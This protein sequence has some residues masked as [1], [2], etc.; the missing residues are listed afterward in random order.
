[1]SGEFAGLRAIV[2]GGASGI[3]AAAATQLLER[4]AA[5]AVLDLD[6]ASS[7]DGAEGIVADVRDRDSV[8]SAVARAAELLG[9][10]DIV[11]N[12][13]GVGAVGTVADNADDEWMRVLDIN[14]VGMARVAA[15]ALPWLQRS[16]AAVI[17]N[18][19]SI[20]A[21]NG[22]P[23]RA[24]YSA[25]K[26]A[27]L[28]LTFAMAA[29]HVADGIRVNCVCPG[30]A[31]T[32]WIGR[33]LAQAADPVAE[34]AALHARQPIGRMVTPDEVAHAILYLASPLSGSTTGAALDVDGGVT[35]LRVRSAAGSA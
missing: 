7:P 11:V 1:V 15:A 33:L 25:S 6:V 24:L 30:T 14:V 3:G 26:G 10:I 13:A 34:R 8:D 31:S 29:D 23:A 27:V 28:S 2:T 4:G 9:G 32:P 18:T 17:V 20:A 16:R 5:V 35:H 12:N 22:L 19:S 21:L